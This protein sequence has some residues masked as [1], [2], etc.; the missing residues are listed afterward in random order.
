MGEQP[1]PTARVG[2]LAARA[3]GRGSGHGIDRAILEARLGSTGA[4]LEAEVSEARGRPPDVGNSA[5]GASA[6][7]PARQG[8]KEDFGDAERL[9]KR[10]A[11]HELILSFVPG[12]EQ[13]LWRTLT[14]TSTN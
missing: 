3:A 4:V 6:I 10:L 7:E 1:E 13:R 11:A 12:P 2:R 8:R 5:S 14:R 9:V